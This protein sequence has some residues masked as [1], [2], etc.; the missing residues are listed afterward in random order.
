MKVKITI[1]LDT[2]DDLDALEEL[3]DLISQMRDSEEDDE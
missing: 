1:E 2:D 3:L